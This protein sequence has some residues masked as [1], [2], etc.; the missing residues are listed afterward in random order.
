[1]AWGGSAIAAVAGL[2]V[3]AVTWLQL[4][5]LL[6]AYGA[7]ARL[8]GAMAA[9]ILIETGPILASLLV[10]GRMGAGL[11]AE[12]GSMTATEEVD[13]REVLGAPLVESLVA[14]RVVACTLAVPVLTVVLDAA[15]LGG[16][17]IG[18]WAGGSTPLEL[19][20][21]HYFDLVRWDDF[22]SATLK[23]AAFGL[24]V[25]LV[26]SDAGLRAGRSTEEIGRAATRGVVR[27]M[28]AVFVV[29]VAL[30]LLL[31]AARY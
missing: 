6:L 11:G 4:R 31:R 25:A 15:A 27:S 16:G 22:A 21:A 17:L 24:V 29:N 1:V 19:F 26:G 12:L 23:T 9:A 28:V 13:A 18:E 14:P 10:A 2:S 30:T 5:R 20:Q 7:E 8:P 3:G